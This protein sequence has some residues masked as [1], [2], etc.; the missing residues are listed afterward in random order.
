MT[1][2]S[3]RRQ[4]V[5]LGTLAVLAACSLWAAVA[6]A[7]SE[8]PPDPAGPPP[9]GP[10]YV[11]SSPNDPNS[12]TLTTRNGRWAIELDQ[13]AC[14]S[15]VVPPASNV[16]VDLLDT[17]TGIETAVQPL[18]TTQDGQIVPDQHICEVQQ[19]QFVEPTPCAEIDGQC[20]IAAESSVGDAGQP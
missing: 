12:L 19:S 1:S 14:G 20:D 10:A 5:A 8:Q 7:Q 16:I 6:Y 15:D 11:L 17:H 9:P 18:L 13:Q 4:A 2:P 3:L